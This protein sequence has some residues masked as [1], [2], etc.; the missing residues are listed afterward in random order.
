MGFQKLFDT[1]KWDD[2]KSQIYSKT[3]K[4]VELALNKTTKR[5][6]DDF[7]ALISPSAMPYLEQMAQLSHQLTKKTFWEHHSNVCSFIFI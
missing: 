7:M 6:L 1:Y 2:I 3:A 4:D 5:T